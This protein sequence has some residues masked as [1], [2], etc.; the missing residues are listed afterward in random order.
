MSD[1]PAG[2][3]AAGAGI[4]VRPPVGRFLLIATLSA[5]VCAKRRRNPIKDA[6]P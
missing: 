3:K 5:L 4:D 2:V 6:G 1:R